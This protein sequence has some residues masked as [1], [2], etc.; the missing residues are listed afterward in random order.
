MT[1]PTTPGHSSNTQPRMLVRHGLEDQ[2]NTGNTDPENK[3]A[4]QVR[5]RERA[6]QVSNS[7]VGSIISDTKKLL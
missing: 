2:I 7:R 4:E 1:H 5:E 3:W 6:E